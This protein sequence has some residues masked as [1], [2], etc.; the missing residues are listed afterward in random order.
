MQAPDGFM[1]TYEEVLA[2]EEKIGIVS[3]NESKSGEMD[4][5]EEHVYMAPDG[6]KGTYEEVLAYE[7]EHGFDQGTEHIVDGNLNSYSEGVQVYKV[8]FD[9][10][11][12]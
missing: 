6:F 8:I 4:S 1:G 2:Y 12:N 5:H 10:G 11:N 9:C 3:G 7:K